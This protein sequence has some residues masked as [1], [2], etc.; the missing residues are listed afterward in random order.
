MSRETKRS[1]TWFQV[2]DTAAIARHLEKMEAK[3]WR[4]TGIDNWFYSYRRAEPARARYAVTF[5]P[6]ASIYDPALTE[7]QETYADY[8]QAAGWELAA[9]YGPFQC[10]RAARP[11]PAPIETDEAVKLTAIRRTMRK[12]FVPS[13][14]L[15]LLL[16][17]ISLPTIMMQ[18]Q[19]DPF[20][21]FSRNSQLGLILLMAGIVLFAGG[22]LLDYLVWVL[23]SR[24]AVK[25]GGACAKPHTRARLW[26]S[27][28]MMAVCAAALLSF[29]TES[30]MWNYLL[31]YGGIY[32]G[33]I[34][35][36]RWV[37][38]ALKR[39]VKSRGNVR[40]LYIAYA[41][42][43]G[44]AVMLVMMLLMPKLMM[45]QRENAANSYTYVSKDGSFSM[46]RE[47]RHDALP[48]TLEELGYP[49]AEEDHCTYNAD[50]QRSPVAARSAYAQRPLNLDSGL[51][52]LSYTIY[53]T[54][55]P[56]LLDACWRDVLG[57]TEDWPVEEV[58]PVPWGAEKAYKRRD[59]DCYCLRYPGRVA[60]AGLSGFGGL[61]PGQLE[62]VAR[63][64]RP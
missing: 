4:L 42:G 13:Y 61:E 35:L 43:A 44:I 36:G 37:L 24:Y 19:H 56:W 30:S 10:F 45:R 8:C 7:G 6:D 18:L 21:L 9:A 14:A 25:R 31:L 16:P 40:G 34:L 22:L 33:V 38:R 54:D 26:A 32:A 11:D 15:L 57:D 3:G 20:S 59:I 63:A 28:A 50:I 46:T 60:A 58:D 23:R 49:V 51:P 53:E 12:S 55:W 47:V 48:V 41:I 64:L 52:D 2:D 39:H 17:V 27:G 29:M 1:L 62:A 5:F